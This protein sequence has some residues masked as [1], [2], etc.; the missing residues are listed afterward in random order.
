MSSQP[1]RRRRN[2]ARLL[3]KLNP[4]GV[5]LPTG[6]GRGSSPGQETPIDVAAA[7]GAIGWAG[8]GPRLAA[9]V[10]CLRWWPGLF[11]GQMRT[12]GYRLVHHRPELHEDLKRPLSAFTEA[13]CERIPLEG[14]AET[15]AFRQLADLLANRL[16]R[17]VVRDQARRGELNAGRVARESTAPLL[18]TLSTE[19]AA[20]VLGADFLATWARAAI[21]EYRHPN[22]CQA[23]RG[24][25]ERLKL[26]DND[27]GKLTATVTGCEDCGGQGV[28][29][30]SVKR[31]GKAVRISEHT[32][33]LHLATAHE[34]A[35]ALLREL[36][37]RGARML[38]ARLG[39]SDER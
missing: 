30:W 13:C 29:P 20:N 7:L 25:G 27:A 28:V 37:Y 1:L 21:N 8:T 32:F 39:V 33:R 26:Q 36:E 35:L 23:C 24:Y 19:T 22:Q 5:G 31:R 2:T 11:D 38:V 14:P 9:R 6:A 3:A 17:S 18:A 16:A 10:L 34:G 4:R 12:V 15:P